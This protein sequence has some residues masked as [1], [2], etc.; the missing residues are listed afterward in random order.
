MY[1]LCA[2]L[3]LIILCTLWYAISLRKRLSKMALQQEKLSTQ[4]PVGTLAGGI[5]HDFNNILGSILG[6]G[7]LLEEDLVSDPNT[8]EMAQ[9]L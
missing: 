5:A 4:D 8:R 7:V 2:F 3:V 9:S 6:F 1:F